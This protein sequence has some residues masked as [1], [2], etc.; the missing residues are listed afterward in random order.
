MK[1]KVEG[2]E[3]TELEGRCGRQ[4]MMKNKAGFIKQNMSG[5]VQS[6]GGNIKTLVPLVIQAVTKKDISLAFRIQL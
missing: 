1:V 5:N 6:F 3:D 2:M 4:Y